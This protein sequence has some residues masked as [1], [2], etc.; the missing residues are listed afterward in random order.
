MAL[1]H[2]FFAQFEIIEN[3]PIEGDP[4]S[5]ISDTH[6]LA[7]AFGINNAQAGMRKPCSI[8]YVDTLGIGSSMT[9]RRNH[10]SELIVVCMTTV[11]L[12]DSSYSAH[13][14]GS[15]NSRWREPSGAYST[16]TDLPKFFGLSTSQPRRI[17]MW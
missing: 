17:A 12:Y 6:R 7:S 5:P 1:L 16:V 11:Q 2:Q 8:F 9:Q 3:F 14:Y 10:P 4:Q 15:K 13:C